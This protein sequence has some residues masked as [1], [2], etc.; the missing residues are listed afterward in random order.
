MPRLGIGP[1]AFH[2]IHQSAHQEHATAIFPLEPVRLI[3]TLL[4]RREVETDT[5]IDN[6]NPKTVR[7]QFNVYLHTTR[8]IA[9]IATQHGVG[10]RL[11]NRDRYV[12]IAM[13]R[14]ESGGHAKGNNRLN[15]RLNQR[16]I[17]C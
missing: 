11:G 6:V 1:G 2:A 4:Q 12:E 17:G 14:R 7:V 15:D 16:Q 9:A 10:Q 5:L 8:G 3:G 13:A